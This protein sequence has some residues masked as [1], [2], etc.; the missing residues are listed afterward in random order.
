MFASTICWPSADRHVPPARSHPV[1]VSGD[2]VWSLE[3]QPCQG[4]C[5]GGPTQ[6]SGKVFAY[7]IRTNTE[8]ALPFTDVQT[9]S[10]LAVFAH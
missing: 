9:L 3:E 2:T 4:E 8:T 1:F 5:L 7:N 6:R 10:E